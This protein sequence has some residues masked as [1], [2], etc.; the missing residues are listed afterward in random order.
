[1]TIR[2][3]DAAGA[4]LVLNAR[5]AVDVTTNGASNL[6][7]HAESSNLETIGKLVGQPLK[8]LATVD[9]AVTGNRANTRAQGTL[10]AGDL[11]AAG[12]DALTVASDFTVDVPNLSAADAAVS[13]TTRATFL[14]IGGQQIDALTAKTRYAQSQVDVE[15]TASQAARTVGARGTVV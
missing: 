8:G 5:G 3:L 2:T 12:V 7:V 1:L 10:T 14:M 15:L 9:A 6:Q 4:D 13:A 11:S